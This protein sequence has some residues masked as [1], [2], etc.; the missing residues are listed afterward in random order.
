M[1]VK[2]Q[3]EAT[4]VEENGVYEAHFRPQ[5]TRPFIYPGKVVAQFSF[6]FEN[7]NDTLAAEEKLKK[8]ARQ[9]GISFV[10]NLD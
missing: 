8:L 7:N 4:I 10:K 1:S 2:V 5:P 6:E 3:M 9:K